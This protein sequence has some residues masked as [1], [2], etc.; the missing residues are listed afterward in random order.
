MNLVTPEDLR[1]LIAVGI[2]YRVLQS[3]NLNLICRDSL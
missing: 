1:I 2:L 3:F